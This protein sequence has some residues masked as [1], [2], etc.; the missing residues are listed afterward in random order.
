MSVQ[1]FHSMRQPALAEPDPDFE[2]ALWFSLLGLT[3]SFALLH[4]ITA[5]T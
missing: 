3:L 4:V 5:M 1:S 2:V